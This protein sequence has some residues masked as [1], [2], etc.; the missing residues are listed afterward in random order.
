MR[1]LLV[2]VRVLDP[3]GPSVDGPAAV[4]TDGDTVT[5]VGPAAEAAARAV[6]AHVLEVPGTTLTPTFVDA[7]VHATSSGLLLTG[8][9]LGTCRSATQLLDA[10]AAHAA[11][12]DGDVV[13]G[14]GWAE[15]DWADP[16]PPSR[17]AIDRA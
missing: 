16:T 4:E 14:H 6:G 3:A 10:L 12:H 7:H 8:L 15:D 9:D 17:A 5:W 1:S 2:G 13:W 11:G